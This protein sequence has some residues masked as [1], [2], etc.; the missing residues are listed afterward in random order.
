MRLCMEWFGFSGGANPTTVEFTDLASQ[1]KWKS[2]ITKYREAGGQGSSSQPPNADEIRIWI[3]R[4]GLEL[5]NF[6]EVLDVLI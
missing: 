5:K 1:L 2:F 4:Q 3:D 6:L